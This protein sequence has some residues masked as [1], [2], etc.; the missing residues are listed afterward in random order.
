[1]SAAASGHIAVV[2]ANAVACAAAVDLTLAGH[3]VMLCTPSS[4]SQ[5]TVPSA[6]MSRMK[7]LAQLPVTLF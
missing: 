7:P 5:V 4:L 2:G 3:S 6:A 1:M